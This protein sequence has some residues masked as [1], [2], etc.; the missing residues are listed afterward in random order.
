M[1]SPESVWEAQELCREAEICGLHVSLSDAERLVCLLRLVWASPLGLT[2]IRNWVDGRRKHLLDSLAWLPFAELTPGETVVDVGSGAGFPGI[3]TAV[4]V[5]DIQVTLLEAN[6]R[7]CAFLRNAAEALGLTNV[8]VCE[9]RAEQA[10]R[11]DDIR[12]RADCVVARAVAPMPRLVEYLAPLCRVG[13]RAVMLKGPRWREEWADAERMSQRV[14][15]RG[16]RYKE[17]ELPEGCG[18]RA[19]VVLEKGRSTP[20][21]YPRHA[22][23][24]GDG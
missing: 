24:A 13:G 20:R 17:Y 8:A 1:A 21:R 10:A 7:R 3:P 18:L 14:G 23:Q 16:M 19:V 11:S 5:P 15:L 9:M 4:V 22:R 6:R 2:T 12:E